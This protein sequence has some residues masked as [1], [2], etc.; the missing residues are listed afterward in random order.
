M[1]KN[2]LL[3]IMSVVLLSASLVSCNSKSSDKSV[4]IPPTAQMSD[5]EKIPVPMGGYEIK[6]NYT[7]VY[8]FCI[9]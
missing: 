6:L 9:S 5:G 4:I 3:G 1:K 8:N 7:T 2:K